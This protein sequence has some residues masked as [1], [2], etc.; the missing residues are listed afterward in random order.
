VLFFAVYGFVWRLRRSFYGEEAT[1][2]T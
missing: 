1:D 2:H